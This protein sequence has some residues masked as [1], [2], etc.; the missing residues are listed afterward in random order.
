[1][2]MAVIWVVTPC[3]LV[4]VYQHSEVLAAFIIMVMSSPDD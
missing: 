3:S 2:K 4:E 1:M